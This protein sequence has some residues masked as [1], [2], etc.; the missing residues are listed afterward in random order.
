[1]N[2]LKS[3]LYE[4]LPK[5][6]GLS[7]TPTVIENVCVRERARGERRD[8]RPARRP[9]GEEEKEDKRDEQKMLRTGEIISP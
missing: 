2:S 3:K 5:N 8:R 9:R 7:S 4:V 6:R 1:M